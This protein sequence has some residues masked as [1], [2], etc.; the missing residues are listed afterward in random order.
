MSQGAT[1]RGGAT[2]RID[3]F[4]VA[5]AF[6]PDGRTLVVGGGEGRIYRIRADDGS[7]QLLDESSPGVLELS[8]QPKGSL[9]AATGQDG[10]LRVFNMEEGAPVAGVLHRSARW[11]AGLGWRSDGQQLAV[12]CGKDVLVFGADGQ[13][14]RT[15]AGHSVP[16]SHLCWRGRDELIAAGNGA[17]FV[18]RADTGAME[19]FV[20]EGIPQTLSLSA[21]GRIAACGL[22]DGTINFR[23]L[24]NRKRSRM[25]GYEGKVA[26]TAWSANSRYLASASSGASSIVVWD[27]G[28]KGP[29]GS[30]PLQLEAHEERV[31]ALAWQG[32]GAMLA[33][34][35][36]DWRVVLW[37]PGPGSRKPLDIQLLDGPAGMMGWSPDGKRLAVA[38]TSGTVRFFSLSAA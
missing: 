5:L 15:I 25:S 21:D 17:L 11:P 26:L 28:G 37:R 12:A 24:N 23:Y 3:D 32:T 33:T 4:P 19:Q 30:E 34:A 35:G 16:L 22:A 2:A 18:D 13:L 9:L 31:E 10:A 14:L 20:L 38:Q 1:L 36:K 6:S 7:A 8:W 29:E 27:F